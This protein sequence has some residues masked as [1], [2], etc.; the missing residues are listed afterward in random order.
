MSVSN[1]SVM[2]TGVLVLILLSVAVWHYENKEEVAQRLM[3]EQLQEEVE[4][5]AKTETDTV[6]KSVASGHHSNKLVYHVAGSGKGT[7]GLAYDSSNPENAVLAL[8]GMHS[9]ST[10]IVH[11][12]LADFSEEIPLDHALWDRNI[13]SAVW[14]M[15]WKSPADFPITAALQRE[16]R[17]V[18]RHVSTDSAD[19]AFNEYGVYLVN[20]Y[21]HAVSAGQDKTL[22]AISFP[23]AF[24][25][26]AVVSFRS[27]NEKPITK[28]AWLSEI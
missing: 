1:R 13:I 17:Y 23:A 14:A 27:E 7:F 26:R 16:N 6:Y 4:A 28:V 15:A 20:S 12:Q 8:T 10:K 22:L 24:D 9:D 21:A 19:T 3:A 5:V 18:V 11:A 2:I 25:S